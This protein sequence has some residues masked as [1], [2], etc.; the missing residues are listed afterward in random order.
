M[1][2][3]N[4]TI[5]IEAELR[6]CYYYGQKALFHK[7]VEKNLVE[8]CTLALIELENGSVIYSPPQDIRFCDKK[9]N[10]YAFTG[11]KDD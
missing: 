11:E 3:L 9:I 6:P 2:G 7:W 8:K 1:A 5:I 4:G 10:N